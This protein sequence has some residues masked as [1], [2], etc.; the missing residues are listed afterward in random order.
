MLRNVLGGGL[1][2]ALVIILL[3][4]NRDWVLSD[5]RRAVADV[6]A[7]P[8]GQGPILA[9]LSDIVALQGVHVPR[10]PSKA[11]QLYRLLVLSDRA[12][13]PRVD[14]DARR[15]RYGYSLREW[16]FLGMPFGWWNEMGYVLYAEDRYELVEVSLT[17]S[18]AAAFQAEVGRDLRQGFFFPFWA[19]AWGWLYVAGVA[20]YGWLHHRSVARR[21]EQ[22]GIL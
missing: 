18:A 2:A 1:I 6:A 14:F 5:Q 8:E 16:S 22:L 15:P 9:R 11:E 13:P 10:T 7:I 21:R 19:H 12:P 4:S 17:D 20:L 3:F